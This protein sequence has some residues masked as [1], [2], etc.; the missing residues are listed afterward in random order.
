[1]IHIDS[2]IALDQQKNVQANICNLLTRYVEGAAIP[3]I[4]FS[5]PRIT[6]V[7]LFTKQV[8]EPVAEVIKE[9]APSTVT[10]PVRSPSTAPPSHQHWSVFL[11]P[12]SRHRRPTLRW[13]W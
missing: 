1:M 4:L 9:S 5:A 7:V 6:C 10:D 12:P 11:P 8:A 2:F 3:H 13:N